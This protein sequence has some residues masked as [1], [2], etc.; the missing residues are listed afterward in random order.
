[1]SAPSRKTAVD[2]PSVVKGFEE[3]YAQALKDLGKFNLAIFGRTGAGKST[4]IN[5]MFGAD[6]AATGTGRPVTLKT[7]YYEH[8]SGHFGVYD[9]EGIE[10][11]QEGSQIL[12]KFRQM[13]RDRRGRPVE[14]QIHVVWY[15]VQ[16]SDE[17]VEDSQAGFVEALAA[18]G[19]PV[20]FVLTQVEMRDDAIRPE[21]VKL[22]DDVTRR[23]LSL[24]PEN[25]V[26]F[27]MAKK[28][29]FGGVGP[30][31]LHELL[32][33]TFRVAPEGVRSALVAAQTIDLERKAA[34]A[35]QYI[36]PA[37]AAA[38]AAGATPIP[39]ADA[40]ILVPIQVGMMAKIGAVFG[41]GLKKG[42]LATLAGTVLTA[43]GVTQAGRYVATSLLKF[44]PGGNVVGGTI[45]AAVASTFT[46]AVGEAWIAVCLG[47]HRRGG[48]AAQDAP[49]DEIRQLFVNE[50]K[51]RARIG[52]AS[53]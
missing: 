16:A 18:E 44:V 19:V 41:L 13:I 15:C 9:S 37:V 40:A 33:A 10:I 1:M 53:A 39:F 6:V 52:S 12:D 35:R 45:R 21:T 3:A 20:L 7:E 17:R 24:S 23:G 22:A 4:L 29:E 50:F 34:R 42:T 27:T 14:E 36:K 30:H 28:D 47:L 51:Q 46:Y 49:A 11:G 43:G 31:G 26:F 38:A 5:A 32:D 8:P 48:E 25:R 2:V